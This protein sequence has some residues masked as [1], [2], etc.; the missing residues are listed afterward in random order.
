M[1]VLV[2]IPSINKI[3]GVDYHRL[4]VPYNRLAL[5]YPEIE[6]SICDDVP[7]M[8]IEQLKEFGVVICNR[9][10]SKTERVDQAI[11]MI[12]A[13][14]C[15]LIVDMDDDYVL[16]HYHVYYELYK[17]KISKQLVQTLRAAD[18]IT[19]THDRLAMALK[20]V[21]RAHP[22]IIPNG[23]DTSIEQFQL[24]P[25]VEEDKV[26]FGWSGS[27]THLEDVFDLYESLVGC[28]NNYSNFKMLYGGYSQGD[29]Y[30]QTIAGILS[31]QGK[32]PT[33]MFA[34]TKATSPSEYAKFY[35]LINVKLIPLRENRF[36]S[37]KSNLK[38]L[39]AGFKKRACIV[40]NVHPYL[41]V[42][43]EKNCL[44]VS[45]K[46]GWFTQIGRICKNPNLR[47]DIAEELYLDVQPYEIKKVNKIRHQMLKYIW[48]K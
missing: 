45:N 15:K 13:A 26:V 5:D 22:F 14:G 35:D 41:D 48:N 2:V 28:Y 32:A 42:I 46:K 1:K 3:S 23:I 4:A 10:I 39:E 29:D 18:Y 6:V 27:V 31:A 38:M 44:K 47:F 36:N 20:D 24:A 12:H 9:V 37:N 17:N 16:P 43:T 33:D 8:T 21:T 11:Q 30:S 40:S 34:W 7:N 19:V 25:E